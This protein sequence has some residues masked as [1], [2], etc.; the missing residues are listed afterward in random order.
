MRCALLLLLCCCCAGTCR[1]GASHMDGSVVSSADFGLWGV[2]GLRVIDASVV[3][4][5]PGGQTG[6]VTFMLA[7]RAAGEGLRAWRL[8]RQQPSSVCWTASA[9]ASIRSPA[10]ASRCEQYVSMWH[11]RSGMLQQCADKVCVL[12]LPHCVCF[13]LLLQPC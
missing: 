8:L 12:R 2:D 1:M 10:A 7:E 6:A 4:N 3:P 9:C 13:P 5:I 11:V